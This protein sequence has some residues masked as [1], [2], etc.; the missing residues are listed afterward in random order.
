[1]A[2]RMLARLG[3][4]VLCGSLGV[5]LAPGCVIR[6]GPGDEREAPPDLSGGAG[7]AEPDAPEDPAEVFNDVDPEVLALGTAMTAYAAST[8]AS[9]VE[10]QVSDPQ[11]VD[12]ETIQ[13]LVD[14]YAPLA[15]EEAVNWLSSVDTSQLVGKSLT[16][17]L[18][19]WK[20]PHGCPHTTVCPFGDLVT[21]NVTECGT[22]ACPYCPFDLTNVLFKSWCVYGCI[23]NGLYLGGAF[24]LIPKYW[25]PG[26]PY[27]IAWN[28]KN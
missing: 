16:P 8:C 23:R 24:L 15:S 11:T 22:G 18:D 3:A 25:K 6:I 27:C 7:V 20:E 26:L 28:K 5:V 17:N 9:L 12:E 14:Q 13:Q 19:C 21:C 4:L 10:S 2:R 1:M